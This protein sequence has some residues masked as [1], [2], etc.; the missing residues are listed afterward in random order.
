VWQCLPSSNILRPQI[1][2]GYAFHTSRYGLTIDNVAGFELVLPNGDIKHVTAEDEDL[3]FGL[4][5]S[6]PFYIQIG[7]TKGLRSQGGLNNFVRY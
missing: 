4:R 5:V 2:A 1:P 6:R 7:I 3:W